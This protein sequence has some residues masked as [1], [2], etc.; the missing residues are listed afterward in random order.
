[1]HVLP[2]FIKFPF[3]RL[4][5]NLINLMSHF[6][7]QQTLFTPEDADGFVQ[8]LLNR[9]SISQSR[10]KTGDILEQRQIKISINKFYASVKI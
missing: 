10:L 4:M 7:L 8:S 6:F 3:T 9:I 2:R 5:M 1:M